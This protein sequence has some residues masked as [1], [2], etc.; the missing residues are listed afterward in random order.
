MKAMAKRYTTAS[1]QMEARP[2][3][4]VSVGS[5]LAATGCAGRVLAVLKWFDS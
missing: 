4:G 3:M 1:L 5:D 2:S